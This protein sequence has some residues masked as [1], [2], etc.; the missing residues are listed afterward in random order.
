MRSTLLISVLCALGSHPASPS[1]A[2][3]EPTHR[4]KPFYPDAA[5]RQN[6]QGHVV[7]R[8][9]VNRDGGG[10][11]A[12]IEQGDEVFET[13]AVAAARKFVFHRMTD[14]D[15]P[16]R[17]WVRTA[18]DFKL[19]DP[20]MDPRVLSDSLWRLPWSASPAVMRQQRES[21]LRM[22]RKPDEVWLFRIDPN[23]EGEALPANARSRFARRAILEA[24]NIE[25]PATRA[26]IRTLLSDVRTHA[27]PPRLKGEFSPRLG[28]RFVTS[29]EVVD[30]VVSFADAALFVK[31]GRR[32]WAG[33]AMPHW[34]EWGQV[35]H[36]AFPEDPNFARYANSDPMSP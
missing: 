36:A 20:A 23:S 16:E 19:A 32:L 7:V 12:E 13:P 17:V 14:P 21:F 10:E 34:R 5:Y 22:M 8:M 28:V 31:D 4:A 15:D 3:P 33:S 1:G 6:V 27:R 35:A 25:D 26:K 9:L 2:L 24:A 18:F 30:V 29:G 11:R